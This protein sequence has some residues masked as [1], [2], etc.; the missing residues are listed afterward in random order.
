MVSMHFAVPEQLGVFGACATPVAAL[1][2]VIFP[3]RIHRGESVDILGPICVKSIA[4]G[5]AGIL[6]AF[7]R[8]HF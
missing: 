5:F 7:F 6:K 3:A 8:F 4:V 2:P 1:H